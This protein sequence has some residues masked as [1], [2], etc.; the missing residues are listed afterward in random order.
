MLHYPYAL[1][2]R[3]IQHS[4][5]FKNLENDPLP[6]DLSD[7]NSLLGK[8]D[9]R[10]QKEFQFLLDKKM[11]PNYSWGLGGYLERRETLLQ[12]F[13]QMVQEKRFYHLGIDILVPV[14]TLLHAPLDAVVRMSDYEEGGG[15]YG[16]YMLLE[17]FNPAFETFYSLYGHLNPDAMSPVATLL[18]S[19]D[20][21]AR[22]GDFHR[23]EIGI[24]ILIYR[25]LP[26]KVWKLGFFTKYTVRGKT[27]R[28]SS[29]CVRIHYRFLKSNLRS[30]P[31]M[32][33]R[34]WS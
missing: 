13:P 25:L 6:I 15:N 23:T 7:G 16:G 34:V 21:F 8:V 30:V 1:Y 3:H 26:N 22:V 4:Q 27:W 18:K 14:N 10:D 11:T 28:R 17:H 20:P 24:I 19:G 33:S 5:L 12:S 2:L 9:V 29:I 31:F 32:W